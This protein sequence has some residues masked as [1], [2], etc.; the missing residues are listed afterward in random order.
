MG[1][2]TD[3]WGDFT[4]DK[5]L[6][7]ETYKLMNGLNET[8]RM[9]RSLGP[10]YGTEGEFYVDGGG[11]AGQDREDSII[12]YNTPPSTQP[13]LWCQWRVADNM[14]TIEWDGGEKFYNYVEWMEY[15]IDKVL[16]PRGY[17]VN[18]N[19]SWQGEDTDDK[20]VLYVENNRVFTE[21]GE[22]FY[23]GATE[24][25]QDL[26]RSFADALKKTQDETQRKALTVLIGTFVSGKNDDL[27]QLVK[28][29]MVEHSI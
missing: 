28:E 5:E 16:A 1:Y 24:V 4:I 19:C 26:K 14:R 9:A 23:F 22:T 27:N 17:V 6:D 25:D 2:T 20:G 11:H 10:E 18:G 13:G 21:V 7:D 12:D 15:L 3:F 29:I 8:R